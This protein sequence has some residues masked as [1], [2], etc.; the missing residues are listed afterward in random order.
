VNSCL[1]ATGLTVDSCTRSCFPSCGRTTLSTVAPLDY[2]HVTYAEPHAQ[3]ARQMLAAHPELRDLAGTQPTTSLW[4]IALVAAQLALA[5]LIGD[6]RWYIWVPIAYIVGA[7]ID[8]ALWA[9]IHDTCHNLVFR[10]RNGNRWVAI[11]AN[12]PLVVPGAISFGKYICFT[13]ATWAISTSTPA[14]LV[15]PRRA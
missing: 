8:H 10:W 12:L 6:R 1:P 2:I 7:T 4:V 3:R 14:F 15:R 13:I 5:V 11:L 9:L